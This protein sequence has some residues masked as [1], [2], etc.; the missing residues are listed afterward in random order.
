[1][2][3]YSSFI[4]EKGGEGIVCA[5]ELTDAEL[6][7]EVLAGNHTAFAVIVERYKNYVFAIIYPIVKNRDDAEDAA[8]ETFFKLYRSLTQYS[9]GSFKSWLGRIAVNTAIDLERKKERLG[10]SFLENL[11]DRYIPP[12]PSAE[13]ELLDNGDADLETLCRGLP[14]KYCNVVYQYYAQEKSCSEIA[15]AQ[16]IAVRT[17]ESRLYRSRKLIKAKLKEG[18][19]NGTL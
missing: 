9:Q 10:E 16:G 17:V 6:V 7:N 15:A 2:P 11:P 19:K 3:F 14:D 18:R 12:E 1:M 4:G 5:E 13:E 8:Q